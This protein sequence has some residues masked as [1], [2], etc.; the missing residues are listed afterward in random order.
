MNFWKWTYATAVC[1]PRKRAAFLSAPPPPSRMISPAS[2]SGRAPRPSHLVTHHH[3]RD[4]RFTASSE[5]RLAP[6]PKG[7]A[8]PLTVTQSPREMDSKSRGAPS[9][10]VC[11][12][13]CTTRTVEAA[14]GMRTAGTAPQRRPG[15]MPSWAAAT[16]GPGSS[17]SSRRNTPGGIR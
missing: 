17:R 1:T 14:G 11:W 8:R 4:C 9:W 6:T 7:P 2:S 15:L 12:W 13:S 3:L 10:T 5:L 16:P